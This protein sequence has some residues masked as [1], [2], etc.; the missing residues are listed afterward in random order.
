MDGL[1]DILKDSVLDTAK[2]I[3]FLFATY[4]LME[5]IE[6]KTSEKS[7][8]AIGRAGK[9]GPVIGG[10]LG[11]VPQCGF[12]ASAASLYSGRIITV[13]TLIAVFLST[14]DEMLP[15]CISERVAPSVIIE[16]LA[17]KAVVAVIIGIGA[18]IIIG[19]MHRDKRELDIH[20][21][22][23][24]EHCHCDED[25]IFKS[26]LKHTLQIT[27]FIFIVTLLL[28]AAIH[29]LGEERLSKVFVDVPVIGCAVSALVGLIP[30]CAA[31]VVITELYLSGII[32]AGAM[33]AGL[34]TGSGIGILVLFRTN[35]HH[36]RENLAILFT[37]YVS[38][39]VIGS[40][41]ELMGINI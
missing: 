4:L 18:D 26:A 14:S 1:I 12:S 22:C 8:A 30:N 34:L 37:L 27:L 2:L 21:L 17:I 6:H 3:P 31:S 25:G 20:C 32:K 16:I 11:I 15:I 36:I 13:G 41:I 33:I 29:F 5:F 39:V 35:K 23:E 24:E 19:M 10:V 40:I 28:D 38:G 9:F 7:R